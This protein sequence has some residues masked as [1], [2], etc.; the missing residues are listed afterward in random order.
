MREARARVDAPIA[1]SRHAGQNRG[2]MIDAVIFDVGETLV[3]E[4][5]AWGERA[6]ALGIP[7]LTFFA[8]LG[9]LIERR[10][11][12]RQVFAELQSEVDPARDRSS[13]ALAGPRPERIESTDLYPD[14]RPCLEDL[15]ARGYWIGVAGNQ[16]ASAEGDLSALGLPIDFA[17]ASQAAG[18]E[19]PSPEFFAR[20]VAASRRSADRI[21][22]VGDRLDNDVLPAIAAGMRGVFLRRGPWGVVHARWPEVERA[23]ARIASLAELPAALDR[24][25]GKGRG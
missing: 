14:A 11:H 3:D 19:K 4:T 2:P 10:L 24:L 22:Y 15:R 13:P 9:S 5:R 23:D 16:P 1:A 12:H 21:A 8:A 17:L 25:S 7:R 18:V 6:D 20:L